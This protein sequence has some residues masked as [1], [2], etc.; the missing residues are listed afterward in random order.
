M[1]YN[2][3]LI[4]SDGTA[5]SEAVIR[6]ICSIQKTILAKVYVVYVVE[7]PRSLPLNECPPSLLS[8]AREVL[9]KAENIALEYQ[10]EIEAQIIYARTAEDSIL[11]TA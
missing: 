5:A 1:L 9:E 3:L 10:A 6:F 8:N 2:T 11:S 4:P 7:V